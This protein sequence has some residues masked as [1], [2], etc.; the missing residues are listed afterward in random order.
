MKKV[1]FLLACALAFGRPAIAQISLEGEWNGRYLED[2]MDRVP[3]GDWGDFTGL[4][5]NEAAHFYA[6]TWD[7][8]RGSVPSTSARCTTSLTSSAVRC[9]SAYGTNAI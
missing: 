8:S 6:Q 3:G 9:S 1:F 7:I 2:Q 4:P 5:I